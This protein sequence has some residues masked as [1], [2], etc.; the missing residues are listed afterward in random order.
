MKYGLKNVEKDKEAIKD[1]LM[2][3]V[4]KCLPDLPEPVEIKSHKWRYSQVEIILFIYLH[5]SHLSFPLKDACPSFGRI[6]F[7]IF[8]LS[9]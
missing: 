4:R 5:S 8:F 9:D 3:D 1:E 2:M 7:H 6:T